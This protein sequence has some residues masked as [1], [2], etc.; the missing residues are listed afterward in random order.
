VVIKGIDVIASAL[1]RGNF[2][3]FA[4]CASPELTRGEA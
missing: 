4:I 3:S 1:D 2:S